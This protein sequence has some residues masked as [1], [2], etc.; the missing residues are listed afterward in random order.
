MSNKNS[1]IRGLKEEMITVISDHSILL[2]VIA[3]PL[4]YAFLMGT[5]YLKKEVKQIPFAVVDYDKTPTTRKLTFLLAADPAI[6]IVNSP[7][8]YQKGVN[9]MYELKTQGF[10]LFPKGF[11]KGL[12]KGKGGD[13][14]L[15][16][17][18]TRF[19]PIRTFY[20]LF[21]SFTSWE[22]LLLIPYPIFTN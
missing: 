2:T 21:L 19:L 10:L 7:S 12:L 15:Y 18:T 14:K 11:E 4:V 6:R 3:A 16:L 13:V 8:S 20:M 22:H 5:I 9:E 17:N 1:F